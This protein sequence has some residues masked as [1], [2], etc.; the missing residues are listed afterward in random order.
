[1][2][3]LCNQVCCPALESEGITMTNTR[4]TSSSGFDAAYLKQQETNL[5]NLLHQVGPGNARARLLLQL[6][7]TRNCLALAASRPAL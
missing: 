7:H 3:V 4:K 2:N 5:T 1:M 6:R